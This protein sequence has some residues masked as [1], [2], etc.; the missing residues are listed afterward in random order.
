MRNTEVGLPGFR[1]Q[2]LVLLDNVR[3]NGLQKRLKPEVE[4]SR[5]PFVPLHL[6]SARDQQILGHCFRQQP[7]E[8]TSVAQE[9]VDDEWISVRRSEQQS[10]SSADLFV[11]SDS[12]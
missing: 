10:Q 2:L 4:V 9:L 5:E 8:E 1:G 7:Q 11:Q 6:D 12:G 3:T